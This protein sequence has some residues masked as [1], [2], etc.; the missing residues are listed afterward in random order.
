MQ[1][2]IKATADRLYLHWSDRCSVTTSYP[3]EVGADDRR[4]VVFPDQDEAEYM[5]DILAPDADLTPFG[6]T[7]DPRALAL[8]SVLEEH[9]SSVRI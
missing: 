4:Y 2:Q 6:V 9:A 8:V 3:I 1:P 7:W 5:R